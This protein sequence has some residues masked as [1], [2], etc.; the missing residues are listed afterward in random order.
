VLTWMYLRF[1]GTVARGQNSART[2]YKDFCPKLAEAGQFF[3]LFCIK[4]HS[5]NAQNE[6]FLVR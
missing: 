3:M 6:M 5:P 4:A 2:E 1:K